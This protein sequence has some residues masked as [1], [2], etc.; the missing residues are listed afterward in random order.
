MPAENKTLTLLKELNQ[1]DVQAEFNAPVVKP[2]S[3]R[4]VAPLKLTPKFEQKVIEMD[5]GAPLAANR[6]AFNSKMPL[7]SRRVLGSVLVELGKIGMALELNE[8]ELQELDEIRSGVSGDVAKQYIVDKVYGD[9]NI[10]K[11]G[12]DASIEEMVGHLHSTGKSLINTTENLNGD[13]EGDEINFF[14][15]KTSQF[16]GVSAAD[17]YFN[18]YS[19]ADG[20]GEIIKA[21]K[22]KTKEKAR[23]VTMTKACFNNIISQEKTKKRLLSAAALISGQDQFA[24]ITVQTVNA[25]MAA[26]G[27]PQIIVVNSAISKERAK[28]EF[29]EVNPYSDTVVLFHENVNFAQTLYKPKKL[30][31]NA[32]GVIQTQNEYA[33]LTV[34][35]DVN[36]DRVLTYSEAYVFVLPVKRNSMYFLNTMATTWNNGKSK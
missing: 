34:K 33:T 7:K 11:E 1:A 32:A 36:P 2:L 16:G 15:G 13:V 6:I 28:G 10:V 30:A 19:T 5:G 29:V 18:A 24:L 21:W 35:E 27:F 9:I 25:Y 12:A 22:E 26:G 17:Q 14:A 20:L 3:F 8:R 31:S 4:T 23:Y